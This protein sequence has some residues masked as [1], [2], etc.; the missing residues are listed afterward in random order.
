MHT[1]QVL[2][3]I[4]LLREQE[5]QRL[6]QLFNSESTADVVIPVAA[7]YGAGVQEVKQWAS[8]QLK[9]GPSLYP[10]VS[11]PMMLTCV[12]DRVYLNLNEPRVHALLLQS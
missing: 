7:K 8:Q 3:K 1:G 12:P 6:V 11:A 2:N 5:V 4:D 9:E 10:K